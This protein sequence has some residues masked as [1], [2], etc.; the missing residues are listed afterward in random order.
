[1]PSH[2]PDEIFAIQLNNC[3]RRIDDKSNLMRLVNEHGCSLKRIRRSSHW[4]LQG[5][6]QQLLTLKEALPLT[7]PLWIVAAIEKSLPKAS[8]NLAKLL[9]MDP[10]L[11]AN[12]L[13]AKTGCSVSEARAAIDK[14]EGFI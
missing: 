9:K 6:L 12:E 2:N 1:M 13:M 10:A 4:L 5:K 11:T 3:I 8:F 7:Q 14:A